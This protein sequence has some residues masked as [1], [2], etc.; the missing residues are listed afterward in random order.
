VHQQRSADGTGVHHLLEGAVR[1]VVPAHVTDLDE[2]PAGSGLG[3]EDLQARFTRLGQW[4]LAEHVLPG[5]DRGQHVLRVGRS[6]RGDDDR[7]HVGVVDVEV[8]RIVIWMTVSVVR[9][10]TA[11]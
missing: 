8:D 11:C 5:R 9:R 6:P 4:L 7:V 2:P 3:V 1:G 10:W